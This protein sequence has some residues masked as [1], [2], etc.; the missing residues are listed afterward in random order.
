MYAVEFFHEGDGLAEPMEQI[1]TW[2]DHEHVQP[3]VFRLSLMLGGTVFRVEFN[4]MREAEAFAR[5]FGGQVIRGR[6]RIGP[7]A[8]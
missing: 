8:A 2:L 5:A 6:E 4:A 3:S 7:V 1:R